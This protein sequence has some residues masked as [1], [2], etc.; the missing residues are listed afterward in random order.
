[1]NTEQIN[2]GLPKEGFVK[3]DQ[4][5]QVIPVS[6]SSWYRGIKKGVFPEGKKLY[7]GAVGWDVKSIRQLIKSL[8]SQQNHSTSSS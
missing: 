5:L 8:A 2:H 7:G 4:I 3:L 1:M 6:E